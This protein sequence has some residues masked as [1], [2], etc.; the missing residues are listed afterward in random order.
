MAPDTPHAHPSLRPDVLWAL[1]LASL[2]AGLRLWNLN[3]GLP[4]FSEE[5]I[6]FRKALDLWRRVQQMHRRGALGYSGL[7]Q[8]REGAV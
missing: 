3:H 6:V 8:R 1:A 5:A 2:A 7:S 4:E